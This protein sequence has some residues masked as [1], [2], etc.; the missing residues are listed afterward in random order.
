[1]GNIVNK[2]ITKDDICF[3]YIVKS[4]VDNYGYTITETNNEDKVIDIL[5]DKNII[6]IG[7]LYIVLIT[8]F[9]KDD[10][11]IRYLI[12]PFAEGICKSKF[13]DKKYS[14]ESIINSNFLFFAGYSHV[15][16][17]KIITFAACNL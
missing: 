15:N 4:L 1:M 13:V 3:D 12:S 16:F 7:E 17:C 11:L 8:E 9:N 14:V 2:E 6:K 10:M 5:L